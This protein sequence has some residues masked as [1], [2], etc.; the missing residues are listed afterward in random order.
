MPSASNPLPGVILPHFAALGRHEIATLGGLQTMLDQITSPATADG[1]GRSNVQLRFAKM[2]ATIIVNRSLNAKAIDPSHDTSSAAHDSRIRQALQLMHKNLSHR[3][4]LDELANRVIYSRSGFAE[5]FKEIV[6]E[7][8]MNYLKKMRMHY[9]AEILIIS[10]ESVRSVAD[11]AGYSCESS[12][13]TAFLET[14]SLP[15]GSYR[16]SHKVDV[17]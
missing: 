17:D 11:L 14:M 6:H 15:P 13:S 3:W 5:R 12:F 1:L 9:A 8:P 2:I 16:E 10:S 7:T 4:S